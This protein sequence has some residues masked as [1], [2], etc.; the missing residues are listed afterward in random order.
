MPDDESSTRSHCGQGEG[1]MN[2]LFLGGIAFVLAV[3][4]AVGIGT[5]SS[6]VAAALA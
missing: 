3:P 2:I 5:G 1:R 6:A 4:L